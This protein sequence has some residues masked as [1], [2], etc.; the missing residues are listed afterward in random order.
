MV[1]LLWGVTVSI[2]AVW[3]GSEWIL[4]AI[5]RERETARLAGL[6]LRVLLVGASG[7]AAFESGK[8]FVQA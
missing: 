3:V 6:Y 5:V 2:G 1:L 7:W 4:A 8:W